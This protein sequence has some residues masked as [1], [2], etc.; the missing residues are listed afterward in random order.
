MAR[1]DFLAAGD[2]WRAHQ[3]EQDES[4][5]TDLRRKGLLPPP[6]NPA[7]RAGKRPGAL[8]PLDAVLVEILS[9][10]PYAQAAT[11]KDRLRDRV[12]SGDGVVKEVRHGAVKASPIPGSRRP[13]VARLDDVVIWVHPKTRQR[14]RTAWS[15][16]RNRLTRLRK[17]VR[18]TK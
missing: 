7:L 15:S 3:R 11:V 14:K 8:D 9:D 2:A 6:A 1:G 10:D 4:I 13:R 5:M 18:L 17:L 12:K 16:I